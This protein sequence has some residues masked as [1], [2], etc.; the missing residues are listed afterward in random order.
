MLRDLT[1]WC[2]WCHAGWRN[3]AP[4]APRPLAPLASGTSG[5][6]AS[7][8]WHLWHLGLWHLG[9]WHLWHLYRTSI[10]LQNAKSSCVMCVD[11]VRMKFGWSSDEVRMKCPLSAQSAQ[12][13]WRRGVEWKCKM[14]LYRTRK[15]HSGGRL[16]L[17]GGAWSCYDAEGGVFMSVYQ[18]IEAKSVS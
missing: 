17:L 1:S 10:P 16:S 9:L 15:A 2:S 5:T 7:G 18:F 3:L 8:L 11:E 6:S 12:S 14:C 13:A 4:L